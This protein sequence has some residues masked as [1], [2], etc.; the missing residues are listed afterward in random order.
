MMNF[1]N[2]L[3]TDECPARYVQLFSQEDECTYSSLRAV[4]CTNLA[5]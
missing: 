4:I 2:V 1:L 5:A 3:K